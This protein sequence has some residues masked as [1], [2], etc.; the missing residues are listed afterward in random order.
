MHACWGE[1]YVN[2]YTQLCV[3]WGHGR[4]T[5]ELGSAVDDVGLSQ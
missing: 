3:T 1:E 2:R 5:Q 4:I